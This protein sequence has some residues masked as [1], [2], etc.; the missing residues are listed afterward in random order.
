MLRFANARREPKRIMVGQGD[1]K[2][3]G[4][5]HVIADAD[6]PVGRTDDNGF[7]LA[8]SKNEG[9]ATNGERVASQELA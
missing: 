7:D 4:T 6:L 5:F 3:A 1:D 9:A 8:R 2:V